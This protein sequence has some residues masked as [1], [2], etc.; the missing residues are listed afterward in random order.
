MIKFKNKPE[1]NEEFISVTIGCK[2][3]I[4]SYRF[5]SYSLDKL[6]KNLDNDHFNILKKEI[7]DKWENPNKKLAYPYEYFFN[8]DDYEKPVNDLKDEDFFSKLKNV[9]P[10][11]S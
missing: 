3:L 9:C 5:L 1:T 6:V 11:D 4:G 8:N 10:N 7:P 2:R